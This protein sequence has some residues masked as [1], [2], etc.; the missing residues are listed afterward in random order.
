MH[1][2]SVLGLY[3]SIRGEVACDD[4][5]PDVDNQRWT[6]E[7]WEPI[8][9]SSGRVIGTRY[10]C[11]HC[12]SDGRAVIRPNEHTSVTK[13]TDGL[14]HEPGAKPV[15]DPRPSDPATGVHRDSR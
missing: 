6:T 7:G 2:P 13:A 3:W 10:Q 1:P 12:A 11:R 5:A 8:P 15:G 9:I 14:P 4:H